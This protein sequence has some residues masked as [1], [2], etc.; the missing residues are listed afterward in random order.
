M[1]PDHR[2]ER[3]AVVWAIRGPGVRIGDSPALE[4]ARFRVR[5]SRLPTPASIDVIDDFGRRQRTRRVVEA[6]VE[7]VVA[8]IRAREN[9]L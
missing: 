8:L 1:S 7:H 6:D 4:T 2:A 5:L 9:R 3:G